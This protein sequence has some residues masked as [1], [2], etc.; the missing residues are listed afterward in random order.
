MNLLTIDKFNLDEELVNHPDL[1]HDLAIAHVKAE[2]RVQ[3]LE[4]KLALVEADLAVNIRSDPKR[5]GFEKKPD[6][7]AMKARVITSKRYQGVIK[8]LLKAK[9]NFA[10]LKAGLRTMEHRKMVLEKLTDLDARDY[11]AKPRVKNKAS[12]D[13]VENRRKSKAFSRGDRRNV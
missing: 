12:K 8:K 13:V 2:D 3:R 5:F 11:F 6:V 10:A 7:A 1:Y 4:A 9:R